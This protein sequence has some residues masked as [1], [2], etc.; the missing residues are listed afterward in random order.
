MLDRIEGWKRAPDIVFQEVNNPFEGKAVLGK[1]Q[2]ENL[3]DSSLLEGTSVKVEQ[4]DI[5]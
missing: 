1:K 4:T 5:S 2:H 3:K